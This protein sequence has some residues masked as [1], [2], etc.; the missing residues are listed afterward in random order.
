M[1]ETF[2]PGPVAGYAIADLAIALF[3]GSHHT[4]DSTAE[5]F[6]TAAFAACKTALARRIPILLEP[7]VMSQ[8]V[9]PE[10]TI[11]RVIADLSARRGLLS[12]KSDAAGEFSLEAQAPLSE[13]PG[14]RTYLALATRRQATCSTRSSKWRIRNQV[15][16]GV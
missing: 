14:Y 12:R 8:I 1:R 3:D 15:A 9:S 11:G 2:A 7:V 13:M 16:I 6:R 4:R 10:A 5:A